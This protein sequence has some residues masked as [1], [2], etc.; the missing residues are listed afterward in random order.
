LRD[1]ET[2]IS[3]R[4]AAFDLVGGDPDLSAHPDIKDEIREMLGDAVE[5]LFVS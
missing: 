3:A 2:L 1:T 4:R 5:W